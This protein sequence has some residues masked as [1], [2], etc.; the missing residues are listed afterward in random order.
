MATLP[1]IDQRIQKFVR[2]FE[3]H[4]D[5][6]GY[7][8]KTSVIREIVRTGSIDTGRMIQAIDYHRQAVVDGVGFTV[9]ASRDPEVF[10]DGFVERPGETRNWEGRFFYQ[11]G[12]E[13][14]NFE[15]VIDDIAQEAFA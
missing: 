15:M 6:F 9:D 4:L 14:A 11:R 13:G 10:Y 5:D 2:G 12:I 7:E 3:T 1:E 8:L